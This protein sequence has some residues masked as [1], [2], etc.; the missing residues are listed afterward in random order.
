MKHSIL[1][2]LV[3]LIVAGTVVGT[4]YFVLSSV[5]GCIET[6]S[7]HFT[8]TCFGAVGEEAEC[9]ADAIQMICVK[10]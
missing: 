10:R 4:R 6:T 8:D 9:A 5:S 1:G 3:G 2:L 7:S